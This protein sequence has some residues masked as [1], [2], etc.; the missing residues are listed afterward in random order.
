M[1]C[2]PAHFMFVNI[3]RSVFHRYLRVHH[4]YSRLVHDPM[5]CALDCLVTLSCR[6]FN[7]RLKENFDGKHHCELLALD[8]FDNSVNFETSDGNTSRI[9]LSPAMDSFMERKQ[10]PTCLNKLPKDMKEVADCR[11]FN[12][13]LLKMTFIILVL[14][15]S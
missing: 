14:K 8:K 10:E 4:I 6:S 2:G 1:H 15:I 9:P 3:I 11:I 5:Q 12:K 7:F 13:R